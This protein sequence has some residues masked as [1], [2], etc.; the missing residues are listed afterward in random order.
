LPSTNNKLDNN[1]KIPRIGKLFLRIT[2]NDE[3]YYQLSGDLEEVFRFKS[4]DENPFR[5]RIWYWLQLFKSIPTFIGL[6][7]YWSFAMLKNY[8]KTAFRNIKRNKGFSI[9]NIV[10]LAIGITSCM[11]ILLFVQSEL[12]YDRHHKNAEHI[13]RAALRGN[14]GANKVDVANASSPLAFTLVN[15]FPEVLTATR[16]R[17][18]NNVYVKYKDKQYREEDF[19]WADSTVFDVFTIPLISGDPNTALMQPNSVLITSAI[20][21]KYFSDE[22]PIN[23]IL[24]LEDGTLYKVTGILQDLPDNSH[25]KF[26]FLASYSTLPES[27]SSDWFSNTAYTYILCQENVSLDQLNA[28]LPEISRK[29]VGPIIQEAM[30]ITYNKFIESGNEFGFFLQPLLDIH[31]HSDLEGEIRS[32]GN[33]NTV[34]IFSVIAFIILVIACINFINIATARSAQR[35]N[36][37]GVRK[38][39]GSNK[40]QLIRQFLSESILLSLISVLLALVLVSLFLPTFNQLVSKN[41]TFSILKTWYFI[42]GIVGSIFMI[43]ILAGGYP[44]FLLASFQPVQVLKGKSQSNRRGRKLRNSLVIFQF[45]ISIILFIGT[46]IIYSQLNFVRNKKL[47]FNKEHIVVIQNAKKLT[48]HQQSFKNELQQ[49]INIINATYSNGLPQM[50]LSGQLFQKIGAESNENHILVNIMA[51]YDFLKTYKIQMS[52]GRFF[53]PDRSTDTSAIILNETAIKAL[54]IS[55]IQDEQL[56]LVGETNN[57]DI[58][59]VFKDFHIQSLHEAIRPMTA[60][61]IKELPGEFLSVRI[62]PNKIQET[63]QFIESQWI[64]FLPN[65]PIEYTF[66]DERFDQLYQSELQTSQI[67]KYFAILTIFIACLGLLGLASFTAGQR[68]K[69]IGIRKVLGANTPGLFLLLSKEFLK[70][71]IVA[72]II[73]WPLA[74]FAMN[75]WLQ[76]FVYHADIGYKVFILSGISALIIALLTV[77]YQTIKATLTNPVNSLKHE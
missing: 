18:I 49:N 63:L 50:R 12:N 36:E 76:N 35:A 48:S 22:D 25:F 21:E 24:T 40:S 5:A 44:A 58:I 39:V 74:Y 46:S 28:K 42:P 62:Q 14:M 8:L 75:K 65:Q 31:L 19:F 27:R 1:L 57:L 2:L 6:T 33:L 16:L 38:V 47:G 41:L 11:L 64:T 54:G 55:N 45:A 60:V 7:I 53:A 70:W 15:E 51:D 13:Y 61:L 56:K 10:G 72:N 3:D 23:K 37:V 4:S 69:E 52:E 17:T 59:G 77:S 30:G 9:I 71:V 73:A 29:Y 32:N 26:D 67:F 43:G 20:V 68:T 66:F 34:M